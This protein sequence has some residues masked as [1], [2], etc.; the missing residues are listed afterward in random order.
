MAIRHG[1]A[2]V[3]DELKAAIRET[4]KQEREHGQ[5]PWSAASLLEF[6]DA[7]AYDE[8]LKFLDGLNQT[9]YS[10]FDNRLWVNWDYF[11]LAGKLF[12]FHRAE[13]SRRVLEALQSD[14][15]PV[16]EAGQRELEFRFGWNFGFDAREFRPVRREKFAKLRPI[17]ER[18]TNM[19]QPEIRGYVLRE[20]GVKL[21][22]PA[23]LAWLPA[24]CEAVGNQDPVV[25]ENVLRLVEEFAGEV[26][27]YEHIYRL[28]SNARHRAL[29]AYLADRANK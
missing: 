23:G 3:R 2:E 29:T 15:L 16:R 21:D 4:V 18:L 1:H 7:E 17:V 12:E 9:N 5:V 25:Y 20:R 10:P 27:C 19:T 22:G 28:N 26:G 14:S 6:D 8:F 13:Y 24:L 11:H